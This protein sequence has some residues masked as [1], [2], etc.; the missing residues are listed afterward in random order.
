VDGDAITYNWE[1]WDLAQGGNGS[2]WNAGATHS[3][4]P[5][6]K[7]RIPSTLGRRYF[8]SLPVIIA[9]YPASPAAT[10]D[11]LK[12]ETLASVNRDMKFRLTL[13]DN[14]AGGGGVATGGNGCSDA[15]TF[16]VKVTN[17][18]P[19]VVTSPNTAVVWAGNSTQTVSWNVANT[20]AP[21]GINTQ[22]VDI[23]MS[24]DGGYTYPSI[25]LSN[26][27]ND[28]TQSITVPNIPTTTTVRFMIKAVGN[29]YF[30]ISD[31]DFTITQPIPIGLLSF[32]VIS[33]KEQL[34]LNWVTT[35]EI[36]NKGFEILR[37][38]GNTN[39][40]VQIG[41]VKGAGNNNTDKK[42]SITDNNI[43]K[44]VDYFY[45]LRQVDLDGH[46][47]YS[48]VQRG[49]INEDGRF[50]MVIS[51]NPVVND[52]NISLNGLSKESFTITVSDMTGKT[53]SSQSYNNT[54]GSKSLQMDMQ[55]MVKGV[56]VLKV[57]QNNSVLTQK[58]MKQ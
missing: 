26:T 46:P 51:P 28:G 24:T 37:S 14:K 50:T 49:R 11:G 42:Y 35:Q 22:F 53:I 6:F 1:E 25:I 30:D 29:I 40:F 48:S 17:D 10:M 20:N 27:P 44:G 18:G 5:L 7:S 3:S 38:E 33:G 31:V 36:N 39:N 16:T 43:R 45:Q 9:G 32:T 12:G 34:Q 23:L 58:V 19:F 21:G 47:S 13:R 2:A 54:A 41:F 56:Y 57:I 4:R 52:L 15:A 8:P 55:N